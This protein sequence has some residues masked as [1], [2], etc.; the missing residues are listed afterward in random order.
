MRNL[1]KYLKPFKKQCILGPICKL[2]E[3]ILE[4]LLPTMMAFVIDYGVM[5]QDMQVV[6]TLTSLMLVMV[7]IGF[8]F[9]ITC[10]Y[11]AALASQG[12]GT[13]LRNTVFQHIMNFSYEDLDQFGTSS[14]TNRLSS[15]INQLQVAVA[16]LIRLVIRA[17]FIVI[18][19]IIMAMFLNMQLAIILLCTIP[20]IA[21]IL[22]LFI[23]ASIPL[24]QGYQ[25]KLD[26]FATMLD[27]NLAGVRVIRAFVSQRSEKKR[28]HAS[29][30]DLHSQM[31][32]VSRLSALLNPATA[33]IVNGAIVLLLWQGVLRIQVGTL[34]PGVIIAL[35]N[36]ATQILL[37]LVA[38]SNLIVIFTKASA[39]AQRINAVLAKSPSMEEGSA[40]TIVCTNTALQFQHVCFAYGS[41]EPALRDISFE[42]YKGES[43]GIIGGTGSGK[44]TLAHLMCRFYDSTMGSITLFEQPITSL[45]A[46]VLQE[47]ICIV[48]QNCELFTASIRDNLT[49]GNAY[50][51]KDLLCALRDAQAED[52]IHSLPDGI[53]TQLER[54]GSNLSGGQKQRL[55]I[56]RG[57]LTKAKILILDDSCSA[58]DFKTDAALRTA[59]QNREFPLTRIMISQRV[60]TLRNC[61]RILVLQDG[62]I[63]GFAP[64]TT[65]YDTCSVYQ[66]I[67]STQHMERMPL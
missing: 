6:L 66:E 49:L 30:E 10:Q 60:T 20:F 3:A 13:T 50:D 1:I 7:L 21:L 15:D 24:Y 23:K 12:F 44:S 65:L 52:F 25:Q 27:D 43:I 5:K 2:S 32:H 62:E 47:Q 64:H 45:T 29:A 57:L 56:A 22:F 35:I 8:G 11:L 55:C 9:S 14:L 67:C 34:A 17:P 42:I 38:I 31:M 46:H 41:G 39:S 18:G 63:A 37:A 51:E 40:S 53:D 26:R 4:L 59:L 58:L 28:I 33:F 48:P 19:A 16:M 54:G 61:D 36:Y